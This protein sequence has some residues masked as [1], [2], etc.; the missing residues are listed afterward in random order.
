MRLNCLR[1]KRYGL[2]TDHDLDF[3]ACETGQPDFHIVYGDN[4]AGKSTAQAAWLD[5][6]FGI[7]VRKH[8]YSYLHG[9]S[10]EVGARLLHNNGEIEYLRV[11]SIRNSLKLPDNTDVNEAKMAE[12]L[13]GL[14]RMQYELIY[15]VNDET[16]EKGG[17]EIVKS[18]GDL[19]RLLFSA[20]SGLADLTGKLTLLE[21]ECEEFYKPRGRTTRLTGIKKELQEIGKL[22]KE[23]EVTADQYSRVVNSVKTATREREKAEVNR[24]E[25]HGELNA[26]EN[27]LQAMSTYN[28]L[29]RN[30]AEQLEIGDLAPP[31]DGWRETCSSLANNRQI[32]TSDIERLNS[33][34]ERMKSDLAS[35]SADQTALKLSGEFDRVEQLRASYMSALNDLPRRKSDHDEAAAAIALQMDRLG[36]SSENAED[37]FPDTKILAVIRN[38]IKQHSGIIQKSSNTRGEYDKAKARCEELG[39]RMEATPSPGGNMVQLETLLDGLQQS[40]PRSKHRNTRDLYQEAKDRC[41]DIQMSISPWSGTEEE[42]RSLVVPSES[43]IGEWQRK[44]TTI[45]NTMETSRRTITDCLAS[46]AKLE[47]LM[48][49]SA[50]GSTVTF[51]EMADARGRREKSWA[52]HVMRLDITSAESFETDMRVH[53]ELV[54]RYIDDRAREAKQAERREKLAELVSEHELLEQEKSRLTSS[55]DDVL[56][57][58]DAIIGKFLPELPVRQAIDLLPGWL[59]SR[60][61]ALETYSE[62]DRVKTRLAGIERELAQLKDEMSTT[63]AGF[64]P[65]METGQSLDALI[66]LAHDLVRQHHRNAELRMQFKQAQLDLQHREQERDRS[67]GEQQGWSDHWS[68]ICKQVAFGK[69]APS[70]EV[71]NERLE[72]LNTLKRQVDRIREL[73]HRIDGMNEDSRAFLQNVSEMASKLDIGDIDNDPLGTWHA[74]GSCIRKA[75]DR[76]RDEER[77]SKDLAEREQELE[78]TSLNLKQIDDSIHSIGHPYGLTMIQELQQTLSEADRLQTLRKEE[79]NLISTLH[80]ILQTDTLAE[81]ESELQQSDRQE[82]EAMK[83]VLER[84]CRDMDDLCNEKLRD[85]DRLRRELDNISGDEDVARLDSREAN[86]ELELRES[87]EHHLRLKL[88]IMAFESKIH[89]FMQSHRSDMMKKASDLFGQ[90]TVGAY[91]GLE[92]AFSD[93]KEILVAISSSG[94]TKQVFELSKG[95]RF[96]LFLALRMAGIHETLG[97]SPALPF[98]ADDVLETFDDNRAGQTLRSLEEL[99]RSTQVIYFTHH[100][101]LCDIARNACGHVN[102][103]E[104]STV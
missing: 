76:A 92:T 41:R 40:D 30:R 96:Q 44:L 36:L 55:R 81:H 51:Q 39:R 34:I 38:L 91:M 20:S 37:V 1:L 52:F 85:H 6:L 2:F 54:N 10:M 15:S 103:L 83:S 25:K 9:P 19:G 27:R 43:M 90:I 60:K 28:Q 67:E 97:S 64:L 29:C 45:S 58:A 31:G 59:H 100:R 53:D 63:L 69:D 95:T 32:A 71:M 13:G 24:K 82:L 78:G 14:D 26:V 77:I 4:E 94:G 46:I 65:E 74:I 101:H 11:K 62:R 5:F 84:E 86:L 22:R 49:S 72:T 42:L 93:S 56:Q 73:K 35:Q 3:G 87:A 12:L 89:R 33:E 7:S 50:S 104:L 75:R 61:R 18:R 79:S 47:K 21:N 68:S 88:G 80:D 99:S 48:E 102:I 16:L 17:E 98:T 57:E 23:I 66:A 8:P 70:V